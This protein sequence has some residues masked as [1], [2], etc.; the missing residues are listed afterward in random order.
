MAASAG[1]QKPFKLGKLDHVEAFWASGRDLFSKSERSKTD[2]KVYITSISLSIF[3]VSRSG[4][5]SN[6]IYEMEACSIFK[7][8]A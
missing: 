3:K 5:V 8:T 7:N 2:I 6:N 4:I 1:E